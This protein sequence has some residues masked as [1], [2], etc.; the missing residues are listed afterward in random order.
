MKQAGFPDPLTDPKLFER[1]RRFFNRVRGRFHY[2][3]PT[4]QVK[5]TPSTRPHNGAQISDGTETYDNWSGGVVDAPSDQSFRAVQGDWVVPNVYAPAQN[6]WYYCSNWIGL[7]GDGSPGVCQAGMKCEVFQSGSFLSRSVYPWHEWYPGNEVK[8]T[9]LAIYP[10]DL[11]SMLIITPNGPGSTT[12]TISFGNQTSGVFTSYEITAPG[13][14]CTCGELR[15]MDRRD[16]VGEQGT[17]ATARLWGD[18][19]LRMCGLFDERNGGQ[20]RNWQQY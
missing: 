16:P 8:I 18:I 17:V 14:D 2:I 12:A 13:G 9:N 4:F 19:L 6:Q 1:Y 5:P 11:I 7:D 10:G 3:E 20:R 15:R